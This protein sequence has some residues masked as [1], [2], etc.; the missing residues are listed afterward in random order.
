[1]VDVEDR[2][3]DLLSLLDD[4]FSDCSFIIWILIGCTSLTDCGIS[5]INDGLLLDKSIGVT[6]SEIDDLILFRSKQSA[7]S[8][9]MTKIEFSE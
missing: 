9:F 6:G 3:E 1:M 5:L 7:L 2:T 8:P 4:C